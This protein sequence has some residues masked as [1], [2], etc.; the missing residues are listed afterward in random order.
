M[1]VDESPIFL[2][3]PYNK[4]VEK[5]S[6]KAISINTQAQEKLRI[7]YLLTK[8]GDGFK[9]PLYIIFK[10]EKEGRIFNELSKILML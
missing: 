1:N 7:T 2:N 10:G 6:K 8:A 4:T 3:M 5:I 9:V